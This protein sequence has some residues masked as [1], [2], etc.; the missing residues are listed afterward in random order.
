MFVSIT[1]KLFYDKIH[2]IK[3]P[4]CYKFVRD[5]SKRVL[6][7]KI[8]SDFYLENEYTNILYY[9][10][11]LRIPYSKIFSR[12]IIYLKL[13]DILLNIACLF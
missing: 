6:I 5:V 12:K 8:R 9:D 4:D 7:A 11:L 2:K 1:I 10:R 13:S 3:W